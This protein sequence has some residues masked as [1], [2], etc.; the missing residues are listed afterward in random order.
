[1]IGINQ[2][3]GGGVVATARDLCHGLANN[4]YDIVMLEPRGNPDH[5]QTT[6]D[7]QWSARDGYSTLLVENWVE[8]IEQPH[9]HV[10]FEPGN[11]LFQQA[12]SLTHPDIVHIHHTIT[13]GSDILRIAKDSGCQVLITLHDYWLF[14]AAIQ[15][16]TP[17]LTRCNGPDDGSPCVT[18]M[19]GHYKSSNDNDWNTR[20]K[21]NIA[22]L[23]RYADVIIAVSNNLRDFVIQ[24]GVNAR[25]VIVQH[26]SVYSVDRL[27]QTTS[28]KK[29]V[30]QQDRLTLTYIGSIS[31]HKGAHILLN[32]IG[33]L[34]QHHRNNI[35]VLLYGGISP[36]YL[37]LLISFSKHL[38]GADI[39]FRGP[40]DAKL[41]LANIFAIT[42][43][44]IIPS[45]WAETFGMVAEEAL[46]AR[47]PVICSRIGGLQEHFFDHVQ[48]RLFPVGNDAA[49]TTI[50][51]EVLQHKQVLSAWQQNIRK[52][53]LCADYIADADGL[54]RQLF[55][56]KPAHALPKNNVPTDIPD[57]SSINNSHLE[58]SYHLFVKQHTLTHQDIHNIQQ[59][60]QSWSNPPLIHL[61]LILP[62]DHINWLAY[63]LESLSKQIYTQW[64]LSVLST[65]ACPSPA[66]VAGGNL[67]WI[68][69]P[70][71]SYAHINPIIQAVD[72]EWVG[73]LQAGDRLPI[74]ALFSCIDNINKHPRWHMVYSDDD[75]VDN[76]GN[77]YGPRFKPDFNPELL[78][79]QPYVEGLCLISRELLIKVGGFSTNNIC[80]YDLALKTY[81]ELGASAIGHISKILLHRLPDATRPDDDMIITESAM[82]A[83]SS[84]LRRNSINAQVVHGLLPGTFMVEYACDKTPLI[85]IIILA[86]NTLADNVRCLNSILANTAYTNIE[87]I[88][89][90]SN[91]MIARE[92]SAELADQQPKWQMVIYHNNQ[93]NLSAMTN[94]GVNKAAGEFVLLLRD[95][96]EVTHDDWL[97]RLVSNGL[98]DTIG[99]VGSRLISTDGHIR[100]AG[101]ILGLS[102][103][104]DYWFYNHSIDDPGYL[105]RTQVAQNFSAVSADCML[106]N[107]ALFIAAGGMDE[108]DFS[109]LYNDTDLCLRVNKL[110]KQIIWTPFVTLLCHPTEVIATTAKLRRTAHHAFLDKWLPE[111]VNDPNFNQNLSLR[112][113]DPTIDNML[114]VNWD[115]DASSP[116]RVLG[117]TINP[118]SCAEWRM[119]Q[120]L[121][122]LAKENKVQMKFHG[123]GEHG[124]A[125]NK[126]PLILEIARAQPDTLYAQ[127][128]LHDLHID[129]I[130][131]YRKYSDAFFVYTLD[132]NFFAIPEHNTANTTQYYN[133]FEARISKTLAVCDR[134]IVTTEPLKTL[135]APL[136]ND[137]HV[138]PNYLDKTLW[139]DLK[140]KRCQGKKPRVGWAGAS[141][142]LS[143]LDIL[144][145]IIDATKDD[146][147]WIIMGMDIPAVHQHL[148]ELHKPVPF[149]SYPKKL[150]SLNL[151]LALA[152]LVDN[153]F[154][155][156]KS[157]LRLLEY[158]I[159]GWPVICSDVLPYQDSPAI[160]V[161]NQPS[162][163]IDAIF[164][165]ISNPNTLAAKGDIMRQWVWDHWMLEDHLDQWLH[166]LFKH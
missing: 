73:L 113:L 141:Q 117:I 163:W 63:T 68:E 118:G 45:V 159:M 164:K 95:N 123:H 60:G 134:L 92:L 86:I 31:M 78:H 105:L 114:N 37:K 46:A 4:G 158:G 9:Q 115:L 64:G 98:R 145:P 142:H 140:S 139:G 23:N 148:H 41:D 96:L 67:Q 38:S 16:F 160:K 27:W 93:L 11:Q 57:N 162:A 84:H 35:R 147:E 48:G 59:R 119:H 65:V 70:N 42:D 97:H 156:G 82:H 25:K 61:L 43:L 90:T 56:L 21:N 89:V 55:T 126:A 153:A 109:L 103:S 29:P 40:Y 53:R 87:I 131:C 2:E 5:A 62:P 110:G 111:L 151:D 71:N 157:N 130:Q 20:I 77:F 106:I 152:P 51:E 15:L 99:I 144:A 124:H 127:A 122:A 80:N 13:Y 129:R 102:D 125:I 83:L 155:E 116:P 136:I 150:A 149:A 19:A 50:I 107:K 154:N 44:A 58:R 3:Y 72:S 18:C 74:H 85:S 6:T 133:D 132:D 75:M 81:D 138:I 33:G 49:L 88:I 12:L 108:D 135:Y 94:L 143:D 26:P 137:I 166:A 66:F 165:I 17:Q 120:V 8:R 1:M 30:R 10:S 100:Y 104:A 22:I 7:I 34:P 69:I 146:V 14:C 161:A 112:H 128:Y 121:N 32:A 47:V 79:C 36:D 39:Q 52:P 101:T 24:Q 91:D 54:Y 76:N 28:T